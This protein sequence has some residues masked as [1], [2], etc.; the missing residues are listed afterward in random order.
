MPPPHE[1]FQH[2]GQFQ[3][4]PAQ[5]AEAETSLCSKIT[6]KET[7]SFHP[8][9]HA[10]LSLQLFILQSSRVSLDSITNTRAHISVS[11][12]VGEKAGMLHVLN[13]NQ[14]VN[15]GKRKAWIRY[16][17]DWRAIIHIKMCTSLPSFPLS[18]F[19]SLK[20]VIKQPESN[21]L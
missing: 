7:E 3:H 12:C 6:A 9:F 18:L 14:Q 5:L 10:W 21:S 11:M 17:N 13:S 19:P 1:V 15:W 8:V 4:E 2:H 20:A 16:I